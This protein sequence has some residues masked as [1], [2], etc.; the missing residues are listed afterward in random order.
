MDGKTGT[1]TEKIGEGTVITLPKPSRDGYTFD[2]WEGSKYN[3][4]DKYTVNGDHTFKAVWKAADSGGGTTPSGDSSGSGKSS[5][6][7]K[8]GVEND[9]VF[10]ILLMTASLAGAAG[11]TLRNIRHRG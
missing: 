1:V 11:M 6:G 4:G 7:T 10:W 9:L 2:Y 5:K 8:T 3:A